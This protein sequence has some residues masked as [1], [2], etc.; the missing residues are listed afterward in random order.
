MDKEL[1]DLVYGKD[2]TQRIVSVENTEDGKFLLFLQNP[3]GSLSIEER[4]SKFWLITNKKA[5]EEQ[6]ELAGEQHYKHI[7]YFN[8]MAEREYVV[9][10]CKA[11]MIDYY[12][13]YDQKEQSLVYNGMTYYKGM[14]P[15]DI[16]VLSFDI[17]TN[18]LTMESD[19]LILII[20]N[21]LRIN[22]GQLVR[23]TFALDDYKGNM[24]KMLQ[25]WMTWVKEVDPN[26]ILGH[27]IL[28]FDI[29][30]IKHCCKLVRAKFKIGRNDEEVKF[31]FI[32]S[33]KRVDGSQTIKYQNCHV[34]GREVVDTMF[35]SITYD[36]LKKFPSYGLKPIIRY[37]GL[38]KAD[39]TFVDAARIGHYY[40]EHINGHSSD[41]WLMAKQYAEEDSDDALKL[42]DEFIPAYFYFANSVSKSFQGMINS[43]TGSQINNMMVRSYLQIGHSIAKATP[44]IEKVKGGISFAVP[45][46]YSNVFKVDI[47]SCYPSQVLRFK[48]HDEKKDPN[49][50]F[51]KIVHFFTYQRFDYK[52]KMQETGDKVWKA[53]DAAAKIVINSA[54][55]CTIT[56]G[57]NYNCPHI[58]DKITA[59]SRAIINLALKWAS[60][61]DSDYWF[62][63]FREKTGQDPEQVGE[64]DAQE[65]T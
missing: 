62:K 10:L 61:Y 47:K 58:G 6:L 31:D 56:V 1:K 9:K 29:P 16:N 5:N 21:T 36:A 37:L 17:E 34:F 33:E 48:L 63:I 40:K 18:R 26:I 41:N 7:A 44:I 45:G 54:Y 28:S 27:N 24:K 4:E 42:F 49:A 20:T 64:E 65:D 55:G 2:D 52:K 32:T 19:S 3:D 8:T 11:K 14:K 25:D 12:R 23:K 15:H 13:I 35:L 39:R 57:L 30:Y 22:G 51:Y 50:H 38:E 53:L 60:G 43:A 59:E 46:I